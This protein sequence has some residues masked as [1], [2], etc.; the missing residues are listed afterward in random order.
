MPIYRYR[1]SKC[2]LETE[3]MKSFMA[4]EEDEPP[5][6]P[7]D[8]DGCPSESDGGEFERMIGKPN[9][10]F[11]GSGEESGFYSNREGVENP[12]SS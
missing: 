5:E 1:C 4:A 3:E 8:I 9:A 10:H 7:E 12:A 6:C 11:S 2:G